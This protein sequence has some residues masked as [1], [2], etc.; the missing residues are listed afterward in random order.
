MI[1]RILRFVLV[2]GVATSVVVLGSPLSLLSTPK[3][4]SKI[5]EVSAKDLQITCTGSVFVAGGKNQTSVSSFK[6]I[7]N[8]SSSI[9][10]SAVTG[11]ALKGYSANPITGYG[12]RQD[13]FKKISK[14]KSYVVLDKTGK[15]AQGSTLLTANQIQLANSKSIKGLLAAPCLRPQSEFWLVGGST[16]IGREALLVLTNPTPIDSTVDLQIFTENGNSTS[17]GL[18]GIAVPAN[19][20]TVVPLS[21][22]VLRAESIA[23]HVV[24]R[25]GS[26]T[27]L[28]QQKAVR[29]NSASGADYV[30]PAPAASKRLILPGILVRGSKDSST[31]RAKA[32]KYSD[33][34]QL[35]RV[36]VPGPKDATITF[37][38]LGTTQETFGTVLSVTASAGKVTDFEIPGLA[39]GDYFGILDSDVK[40]LSSVRLVR[41]KTIPGAYTDFA[42]INAAEAFKTARFIA[43]P[44]SGISKLSVTNP[45]DKPTTVS[46]RIGGT[47]VKR[48]IGAG[49]TEVV[50]ATPG[51]SMGVIPDGTEVYA[52]LVI[53]VDGRIGVLPL[54]DDKNISG[55]VEVSVH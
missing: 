6:R 53:D 21:S 50:R 25:G 13:L 3:V 55:L 9:S 35:L 34:Q 26:I 1:S 27:A 18:T 40:V 46:I 42:W 2:F 33:V 31:F 5:H 41:S 24:S 47:T 38:V 45:G 28:I 52:N 7:G 29:G 49:A 19:D 54:L 22:F 36:F 20:T 10:Y 48:T 30:A 32:D 39:N 51:L 43:V 15:N 23:V 11:T 4:E 44:K 17:A 14:F 8:S 37:Q 16:A 12:V